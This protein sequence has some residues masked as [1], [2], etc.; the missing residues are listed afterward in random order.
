MIGP[1]KLLVVSLLVTVTSAM[2]YSRY[3]P[4]WASLSSSSKASSSSPSSPS[5]SLLRLRQGLDTLKSRSRL[6]TRSDLSSRETCSLQAVIL[7]LDP[8]LRIDDDCSTAYV[9]TFG[10]RGG[11]SSY[12][13]V[14]P[15]NTTNIFHSCSCCQP[16]RFTVSIAVIPCRNGQ[17]MRVPVKDALRCSCRPCYADETPKDM[18]N[19]RDFLT[20]AAVDTPLPI[21]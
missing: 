9:Q 5:A 6:G 16:V 13:Q 19:L 7:R 18:A 11:C 12:S 8:P 21:G 1:D 17:H 10:C 15:R 14:D 20:K 2:L 3:K 4:G